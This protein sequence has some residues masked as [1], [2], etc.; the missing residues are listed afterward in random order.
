[1]QGMFNGMFGKIQNGMCRLSYTG[2]IAVKTNTGYKTYDVNQGKLINCTDF[3]LDIGNDFF[4]VIPTNKVEKG[5]IILVDRKP[6]CVISADK[7]HITVVNYENSTVENV[8]PERHVFMGNT[9]FYGKIVSIFGNNF[10]KGKGGMKKM[11]SYMA[12]TELLKNSGAGNMGVGN[13]QAN[14]FAS[15]IPFMF[16]GGGNGFADMFDGMFDFDEDEDKDG[17]ENKDNE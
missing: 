17:K 5:D 4:F 10:T 8:L 13:N 6:R 3:A 2:G 7:D 15:M 11:F 9:Y 14:G 1:M 16:F 12:M